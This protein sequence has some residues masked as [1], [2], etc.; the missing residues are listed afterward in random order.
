MA[1][2]TYITETDFIISCTDR[3][4][5]IAAIDAIIDAL[6]AQMLVI[7][8]RGSPIQEYMLN[9]G[10]TTIK[11]IYRTGKQIEDSIAVMQKQR[12]HYLNQGRR[13]V[14]MQPVS[15]FIGRKNNC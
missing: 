13:S 3:A 10:Q 5:K 12:N 8:Q 6:F 15:N 4:A 7:A 14:R 11:T 2:V 9:D 1:P